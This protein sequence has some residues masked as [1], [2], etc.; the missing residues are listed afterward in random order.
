M[1]PNSCSRGRECLKCVKLPL[2]QTNIE[3]CN[4]VMSH[5]GSV[6]WWSSHKIEI[7]PM[8]GIHIFPRLRDICILLWFATSWLKLL[9]KFFWK[10]ILSNLRLIIFHYLSAWSRSWSEANYWALLFE[11]EAVTLGFGKQYE[12]KKAKFVQSK[13][14]RYCFL[15]RHNIGLWFTIKQT[16]LASTSCTITT[17]GHSVKVWI[18]LPRKSKQMHSSRSRSV[19]TLDSF[20]A[21]SEPFRCVFVLAPFTVHVHSVTR[22]NN[23]NNS[24]PC[25]VFTTSTKCV[26]SICTMLDQR[27]RRCTGPTLYKCYSKTQ[28]KLSGHIEGGSDHKQDCIRS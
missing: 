19:V 28:L 23:Y 20:F 12:A 6:V 2:S 15:A 13:V 16:A 3:L 11:T 9:R 24:A 1:Y 26:Y 27:R 21:F 14:N 25:L 17:R 10:R 22:L 18:V 7:K 4:S 8:H 5:S